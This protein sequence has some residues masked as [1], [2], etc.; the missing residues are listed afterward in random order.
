MLQEQQLRGRRGLLSFP[1]SGH[2]HDLE[3]VLDP[4]V[5]LYPRRCALP[6]SSTKKYES[7]FAPDSRCPQ[8]Q[9]GKCSTGQ[10]ESWAL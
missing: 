1:P 6:G 2:L 9:A 7:I 5:L 4:Y 8:R 10:E 3:R